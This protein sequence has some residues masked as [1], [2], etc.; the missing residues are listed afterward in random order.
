MSG[1]GGMVSFVV[2]GGVAAGERVHD[3]LQLFTRAGSLGGVESLASV[4]A[5][6]SNRRLSEAERERV[7]VPS[8]LLRLSVGLESPEDLIADLE[9]TLE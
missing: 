7:G 3:R 5:R 9:R 2:R 1:F 8:T 4:P 6:M